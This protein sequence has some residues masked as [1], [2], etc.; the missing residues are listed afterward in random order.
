[1]GAYIGISFADEEEP[2]FF[3]FFQNTGCDEFINKRNMKTI[4][5]CRGKVLSLCLKMLNKSPMVEHLTFTVEYFG[6]YNTGCSFSLSLY[7]IAPPIS[8]IYISPFY[9]AFPCVPFFSRA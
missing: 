3:F 8:I 7:S 6:V 9:L 5:L 4:E 2:R 1:M